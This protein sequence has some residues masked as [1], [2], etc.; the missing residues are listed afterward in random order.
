MIRAAGRRLSLAVTLLLLLSACGGGGEIKSLT[1]K[2]AAPVVALPSQILGLKV[3]QENISSDLKKVKRPYIDSVGL[4]SLREEDL[5]RASIQIGRFN[6][7]ARPGSSK[8]RLSIIALLGVSKPLEFKAGDT[9]I[10]STSGNRQ[11]IFVWFK[12]R[13]LFVLSVHQDYEFP[14]TLL[15]R[16]LSYEIR[17]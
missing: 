7:L 2:K 17:L 15:R 1:G 13:S 11:N 12:E 8:F 4:F 9:V 16:I 3:A 10:Y 14:R 5:L 6:S